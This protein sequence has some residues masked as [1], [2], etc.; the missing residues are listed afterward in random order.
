MTKKSPFR[1]K[2]CLALS[3]ALAIASFGIQTSH[4]QSTW[5]GN[6]DQDWNNE[7]NW[8]DNTLP[9]GNEGQA[10][11][12]VIVNTDSG[13]FPMISADSLFMPNDLI[14]GQGAGQSG[15]LDHTAGQ[16]NMF[17]WSYLGDAGTATYNLADT[18]GTGGIHTGFAQGSGSFTSQNNGRFHVGTNTGSATVNMNTTGSFNVG[19]LWI[20]NGTGSTGIFNLDSGTVNVSGDLR[21]GNNANNTQSGTGVFN[22]SGANSTL[23][24]ENDLR[25]SWAGNSDSGGTMTIA[26]GSTVNVATTTK[27]WVIVNQWDTTQGNLIL[28]GGT[29]NMN[30][31]TDLRFS[32]GNAA[33][34][35]TSVVTLNSGAITSY[36]DN[37]QTPN[38]AGVV[39]MNHAG[40]ADANNT[41]NLNGGTLTIRRV[42]SNSN[43]GTRTFNFNGGILQA[44][45]DA[46][47]LGNAAFLHLGSGGTARVNVRDGGAI[48]DTNG[49]NL[50][51]AQPLQH[52]NIDGDA[53]TDGGLT[54]LGGGTLEL[55]GANTYTGPT[56]IN[57]GTLILTGSLGDTTINIAAGGAFGGSGTFGG[58]LHFGVGTS[59]YFHPDYTL[60]VEG[61]VTFDDFGVGDLIGLDNTVA[62]MT[63]TL[64]DGNV[65]FDNISNVGPD[66]AFDLGN[67]VSAYFQ[68]GSL[69]LVVVP[70]PSTYALIFGALALAGVMVRRRLRKA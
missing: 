4:A 26:D 20:A 64:I 8:S 27:R 7:N 23:N 44:T 25:V 24:I 5:T 51:I 62:L 15:R 40:G 69:E 18:S 38:G 21:L 58:D 57:S 70:E 9:A 11:S 14:M 12:N 30:T 16:L 54:L 49:F 2:T 31:N 46:T 13:N 63:Y 28:N 53:A 17:H 68:G 32:T 1:L 61:E 43:N 3:C 41:F 48:I 60:E 39:D 50:R 37:L 34:V 45:G 29:L 56:N 36:S 19:N 22:I 42:I 47:G 55:A 65:S 67:G 35:G 10:G 6:E 52:S 66:N 59:F 33:S